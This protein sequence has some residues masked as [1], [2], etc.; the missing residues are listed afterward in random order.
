MRKQ[1]VRRIAEDLDLPNKSRKDSQGLCFLGKIKYEEFV[2][3]H[4]GT[5]A[6]KIIEMDTGRVLGT[7]EGY[8]FFTIGQRH[9]LGLSGGP[10]YVVEKDIEQNVIYVS[11]QSNYLHRSRK[12][13]IVH[14][15]NWISDIQPRDPF[16]LKVR[17][18]PH[19]VFGSITGQCND[20]VTVK[21]EKEDPGI[22]PGQSAIFYQDEFCLGG[23]VIGWKPI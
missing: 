4:L 18:G 3:F 1:E 22:A 6:G 5:K 2:K 8:W 11:H 7:H 10:W 19:M 13:F 17:H 20:S 15:L 16:Q 9:G 14:S 21:M 12:E 23:G